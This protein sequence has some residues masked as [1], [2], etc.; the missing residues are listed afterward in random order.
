MFTNADQITGNKDEETMNMPSIETLS[1]M[2]SEASIAPSPSFG[3]ED[4]D[5]KTHC[6]LRQRSPKSRKKSKVSGVSNDDQSIITDGIKTSNCREGFNIADQSNIQRSRGRRNQRK[7]T[8]TS[9][10]DTDSSCDFNNTKGS[11]EIPSNA[12]ANT[13]IRYMTDFNEDTV[14]EDNDNK[15]EEYD[16]ENSEEEDDDDEED[17]EEEDVE[18][19]DVDV[20][21]SLL[22][23]RKRGNTTNKLLFSSKREKR[24]KRKT[25][26]NKFSTHRTY[27]SDSNNGGSNRIISKGQMRGNEILNIVYRIIIETKDFETKSVIKYKIICRIS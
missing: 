9:D 19:D 1:H 16:G 4:K 14:Y 22:R 7:Q 15:D 10:P 12:L 18:D 27:S 8:I 13:R 24:S 5:G 17:D 3:I 25:K 20:E 2:E 23:E 6:N 21:N 26:T 11:T